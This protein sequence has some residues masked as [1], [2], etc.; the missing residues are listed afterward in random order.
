MKKLTLLLLT[1]G[2]FMSCESKEIELTQQELLI[3]EWIESGTEDIIKYRTDGLFEIGTITDGYYRMG[4]Y[5][6]EGDTITYNENR[7]STF[8][9]EGDTL[10]VDS[11]VFNRK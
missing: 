6:V 7:V 8:A 10:Y 1:F 3:G 4:S 9:V 11:Q 5:T 2:F